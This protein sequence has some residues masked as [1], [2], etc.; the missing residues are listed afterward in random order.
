[1]QYNLLKYERFNPNWVIVGHEKEQFATDLRYA[2]HMNYIGLDNKYFLNT[3]I[4]DVDGG[5]PLAIWEKAFPDLIRPNYMAGKFVQGRLRRPHIV[6]H[7]KSPVFK[8]NRKQMQYFEAIKERISMILDEHGCKI[9]ACQPNI[10][11]NPCSNMWDV[12]T[13]GEHF[14]NKVWSLNELAHLVDL[15]RYTPKQYQISRKKR[16]QQVR[17]KQA[18]GVY[19]GRNCAL[20]DTLRHVGYAIAV[21]NNDYNH[22]YE[23]LIEEAHEINKGM[24]AGNPLSFKEMKDTVK[25]IA[26][27]CSTHTCYLP[28]N[29]RRKGACARHIRQGDSLKTRQR[30]GALFSASENAN[31]TLTHLREV[32]AGLD[33]VPSKKE[34]ARVSGKSLNTVRKYWSAIFE[35]EQIEIKATKMLQDYRQEADLLTFPEFTLEGGQNGGASGGK[36]E[37]KDYGNLTLNNTV[38]TTEPCEPQTVPWDEPKTEQVT[39]WITVVGLTNANGDDIEQVRV[40]QDSQ[41]GQTKRETTV[42][43]PSFLL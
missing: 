37:T 9:D 41:T 15:K 23:N 26:K 28:S 7:L 6:F 31:K 34:F 30:K 33:G 29:Q 43:I 8:D 20:F 2:W 32:A 11:K 35:G 40:V 4:I 13:F 36:G 38:D 17:R 3:M 42:R 18:K 14:E 1:M 10:T 19:V 25:S 24:F 16:K 39:P 5:D 12:H 22:L 21:R 27:Y